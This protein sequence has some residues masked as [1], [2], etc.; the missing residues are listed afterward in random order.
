MSLHLSQL[1]L[2]SGS[3]AAALRAIGASVALLLSACGDGDQVAA[4]VSSPPEQLPDS[5]H[6]APVAQTPVALDTIAT[7]LEVPWSLTFTLD[8]STLLTE[9]TGRIRVI[10]EKGLREEPWAVLPAFATDPQLLP[11][12]GLMG[13]TLAPDFAQSRHVYVVGTFWKWGDSPGIRA[14]DRLFRRIAGRVRPELESP[15]ENRVYR[16]TERDGYGT[17]QTLI[18][19][20]L[21]ASHY[22]AGGGIAFGPDGMLYL[23]SGEA[24]MSERAQDRGSLVGKI[25]RYRP[26][27]SIPDDNP[28]PGSPV[29][30]LGF[31]NPQG[32]AWHP[33]S[34]DLFVTEHGPSFLPHEAG[35]SGADEVN[36]VSSGENYG[37]PFEAGRAEGFA[38][39]LPL[40]SWTPGI[41]P[42]GLLFYDGPHLPWQGNLFVTGLRG[43][44]LRRIVLSRDS[45]GSWSV[46]GQEIL[47]EG[48]IGRIRALAM[49]QDGYLYIT[50]SNRDGRGTPSGADDLLLRVVPLSLGNEPHQS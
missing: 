2:H 8:G 20:G 7:G 14:V 9:R 27:G 33:A 38:H 31:R 11:E 47:L 18:L 23:T 39:R 49:G 41:A 45:T 50:T 29:F 13:I 32:L 25:L 40:L 43:Q 28:I 46:V 6:L 10:D 48:V 3:R 24:L 15:W 26:D 44:Q 22:H 34:G 42:A 16:F 5:E 1:P 21:P 17:E 30:A 35:R 19:D 37:W 4:P 36:V 12:S